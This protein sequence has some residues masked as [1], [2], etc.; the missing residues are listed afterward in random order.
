[1][2]GPP[3]PTVEW[4]VFER[5]PWL[6]LALVLATWACAQEDPSFTVKPPWESGA[7]GVVWAE[8]EDG[9]L[10]GAPPTVLAADQSLSLTGAPPVRLYFLE[11][12]PGAQEELRAC[13]VRFGGEHPT[14][15]KAQRAHRVLVGAEG[16]GEVAVIDPPGRDLHFD[17]CAPP[18]ACDRIEQRSV[19][20]PLT[21]LNPIL[22]EWIGPDRWLVVGTTPSS[23]VGPTRLA[24]LEPSGPPTLLDEVLQESMPSVARTPDGTVWLSAARG[25]LFRLALSPRPHLEEEPGPG[26][27]GH[28][29]VRP[30]GLLILHN[31]GATHIV[32]Q[33]DRGAVTVDQFPERLRLLAMDDVSRM[34]SAQEG[35][36]SIFQAGEWRPLLDLPRIHFEDR[37]IYSA[38]KLYAFG[39]TFLL[40]ESEDGEILPAPGPPS[41]LFGPRAPT[42]FHRGLLVG[43]DVGGA[44]YLEGQKWCFLKT[45]VVVSA[46]RCSAVTPDGDTAIF[47]VDPGSEQLDPTII[48]FERRP[49]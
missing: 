4:A 35:K 25:R 17:R 15:P 29:A 40:E 8:R 11:Y 21:G 30:D 3:H 28:L 36:L 12:D 31:E 46:L 9:E 24:I 18:T 6:L 27:G 44:A 10:V 49:P 47:G 5:R 23:S 41:A 1:M 37:L 7:L 20:A 14:L 22:A 42:R 13:G 38:G 32:R 26:F 33:P 39:P 19:K 43:G 48:F 45:E 16:A 2:G 34:A